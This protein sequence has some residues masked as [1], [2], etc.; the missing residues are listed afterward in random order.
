M[1]P[2]SDLLVQS[3][4]KFSEEELRPLTSPEYDGSSIASLLSEKTQDE[5]T[6]EWEVGRKID[7]ALLDF[8][9]YK[10]MDGSEWKLLR[11]LLM[12]HLTT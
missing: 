6:R 3:R 12:G 9:H 7:A 4:S 10:T 5:K 8:Q 11:A 1:K 2:L